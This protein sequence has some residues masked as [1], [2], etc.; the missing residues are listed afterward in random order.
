[1]LGKV[2]GQL[3]FKVPSLQPA[4]NWSGNQAVDNSIAFGDDQRRLVRAAT[5]KQAL[6]TAACAFGNSLTL[7]LV[8]LLPSTHFHTIHRL[9]VLKLCMWN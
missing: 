2:A 6:I 9:T 5:K 7:P 4:V 3:F 8:N 1:M